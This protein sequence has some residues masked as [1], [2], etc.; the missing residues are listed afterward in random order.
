MI[1]VFALLAFFIGA[2]IRLS[3]ISL[4]SG[5]INYTIQTAQ[6]I[7]YLALLL[8]VGI[9]VFDVMSVGVG[10]VV[11]ST[12]ASLI[13]SFVFELVLSKLNTQKRT[14]SILYRIAIIAVIAL[15]FCNNGKIGIT[16]FL[17]MGMYLT[18]NIFGAVHS[19]DYRISAKLNRTS[20]SELSSVCAEPDTFEL[21]NFT[22]AGNSRK[23]KESLVVYKVTDYGVLPN[24]KEDQT[25]KVN[26]LIEMVGQ[27]D[28]G[29]VFF[30]QGKYYFNKSKHN[31]Q[32]IQIN[33]SNI[34]LEGEVDAAGCPVAELVNCNKLVSGKR[35]PWLSPFLI[36][37]GERLQESNWFWGL[38]FRKKKNIITKSASAS[39]PGS[40]G[41]IL[42]PDYATKVIRDSL[43][44]D[45]ILH[46][47][48]ASKVGRY[49]L[50]GMY[51]T[52]GD[53]ELIQ[54]ILGIEIRPE[55]KTPLRAGTEEAPS[56][57][58]LVAV[59]EVIDKHTIRL[60]QPLW[61]DCL[62]K[63]DPS[64]FNVEMLENVAI[65][66]LK[67]SSTWNGLFRHHG[68]SGYYTGR[69]AQE[70]D[71]GWNAINMKRVAYGTIENVHI[72]N[73]T[74]P[75]YIMDSRNVTARNIRISGYDGHQG[76]KIYEHACDN[77]IE[78]I[79]FTCEYADM[80]GGEG[81]A[82]GN[83]FRNIKYLNPEFRPC[84]YDFHGF[85]EG[86]MSPPAYNLFDNIFGFRYIKMAGALYNQ[87]ACAQWN[88][89]WNCQSEGEIKGTNILH[90]L[91][92]EEK[93]SFS[94][95]VNYLLRSLLKIHPIKIVNSYRNLVNTQ[96]SM[97]MPSK[98][99]S[100]LFNNIWIYGC[101]TSMTIPDDSHVHSYN[102]NQQCFPESLYNN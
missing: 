42:Q 98:D 102:T 47:E 13:L 50:L 58:W 85:S 15:L 83:V 37:T 49:I 3:D 68:F 1:L 74:N 36:T 90:S 100:R 7:S 66:N 65:R 5:K 53:G 23:E 82:Y 79:T 93:I 81:N 11:I 17:V 6:Y 69:Q 29:V 67:I 25:Q 39:D 16:Y 35:N 8:S 45:D 27:K 12:I 9:I 72:H 89:W 56:F 38:Q 24:T 10:I 73:Y 34:T 14:L 99:L 31:V 96:K 62:L 22:H 91:H 43:Q 41:S 77:L 87:P 46:V 55:W 26:D 63:Y 92:Y 51:N 80:M 40:D 59:A 32:N 33:Y 61:R 76:I 94:R 60:V 28:G 48:D 20:M 97:C 54:D 44:G 101:H 71:Y 57:Q 21:P 75:L 2:Q 19:K 18:N 84:D 78:N 64:I 4:L 70:M 95:K 86:P 30:P 52:D 88:V